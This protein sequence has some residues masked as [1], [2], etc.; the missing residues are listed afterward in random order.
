MGSKIQIFE[1][2]RVRSYWDPEAEE[3][4]FSAVD[5]CNVL[6]MSASKDPGAYWRKLKQR[7][8]KEGSQVVTNCHGLKMVAEDGKLRKTDC[9]N[10]ADSLRPSD[11]A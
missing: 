9:F 8:K 4:Y 1:G 2:K 10:T 11:R 3:W 5:I 7:L 6:S